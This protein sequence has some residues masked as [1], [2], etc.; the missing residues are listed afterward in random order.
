MEEK[1][2]VTLSLGSSTCSIGMAT[3]KGC[4]QKGP[5]SF[6]GDGVGGLHKEECVKSHGLKHV[7]KLSCQVR[8]IPSGYGTVHTKGQLSEPKWGVYFYVGGER[9]AQYGQP[10]PE[11]EEKH[12]YE[13]QSL[14][15]V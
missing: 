2:T 12:V 13:G 10:E 7:G 1:A 14:K 8:V 5:G 4:L 11:Q 15:G 6:Q 9:F 3:G